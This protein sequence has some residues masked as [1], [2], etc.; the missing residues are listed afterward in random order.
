MVFVGR[1]R[2]MSWS[3]SRAALIEAN[4]R[5]LDNLEL[6]AAP[7]LT[8]L[9]DQPKLSSQKKSRASAG[10]RRARQSS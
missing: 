2:P 5:L 8:A 4:A 7:D 9:V 3:G 10:E 6:N 1:F